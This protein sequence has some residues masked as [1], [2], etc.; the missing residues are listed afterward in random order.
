M[1]CGGSVQVDILQPVVVGLAGDE[2]VVLPSGRQSR[3]ARIVTK[4][5]EL[6]EATNGQAVTLTLVDDIDVARGD[7]LASANQRPPELADQFAAHLLWLDEAPMLPGR[8]YLMQ[9]GPSTVTATV[10][11]L[12]HQ[13]DIDDGTHKAAKQLAVNEIG[14][15]NLALDRPLPFDA[16]DD[17]RDTGGFILIDRLTSATVG[18][19]MIRFPLRRAAN[20]KWHDFAVDRAQRSA[21]KGHR[22]AIL[23]FTGLSGAG[24]STIADGVEK[25]LL[26]LGHHTYTLDGDNVRHGLNRD[27]GFTAADRVENIRRVIETANL[28]ADAGLIVLISFI[29]PFRAERARARERLAGSFFFAEIFVDTPLAECERRDPKGLY[30]KARAGQLQN[31][32]GIDSPYEAPDRPDLHL[33]TVGST[34]EAQVDL[35]VDI[36]RG[37]GV[38]GPAGIG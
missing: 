32:T 19:G 9:L 24:K 27:L 38:L 12:K 37:N 16:Y 21:I 36:L 7:L 6:S 3:V 8:P 33:R 1:E 17:N 5:G 25:R 13:L 30:R 4:D 34:V 11:E 28:M 29:S 2:I 22:P 35:V 18:A 20:L 15:A 23:W 10:S 31:F 26:E 14:F